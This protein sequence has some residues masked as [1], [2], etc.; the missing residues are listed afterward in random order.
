MGEKK[1][2]KKFLV[3][4]TLVTGIV[5][6]SNTIVQTPLNF[7]NKFAEAA[8]I[9]DE[10]KISTIVQGDKIIKGQGPVG[11]EVTIFLLVLGSE[12][13]LANKPIVNEH[14]LWESQDMASWLSEAGIPIR[15]EVNLDGTLYEDRTIVLDNGEDTVARL[16]V[17]ITDTELNEGIEQVDIDEARELVEALPDREIKTTLLNRIATAQ[18]LF[19][20]KLVELQAEAKET[21]DNLFSDETETSLKPGVNQAAIEEAKELVE[22]LPE[23]EAKIALEERIEKAQNL[24]TAQTEDE[25]KKA[26][27]KE[28]VDNLFSDETET[29][30]KP[31]VNQAAIEEAKRLVEK[32]PEGEAKIALEER[33]EKAQNLLTRQTEDETKKAEAKET[34]DNCFSDETETS[35]KTGINQA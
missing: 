21:V 3:G 1:L 28:T 16:F 8:E 12:Y 14:G 25:T 34:A 10:F 29:S 5:S 18:D 6:S 15:V 9:T 13:R 17:D 22:N 32:L 24:L 2:V 4:A 27:A 19:E 30:L 35:L 26:E 23:G 20:I 33:I 11:S 31:G 7:T